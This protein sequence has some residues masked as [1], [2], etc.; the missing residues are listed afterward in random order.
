MS[1]DPKGNGTQV[2]TTR[3]RT[4]RR[5]RTRATR[6]RGSTRSWG[7]PLGVATDEAKAAA[8]ADVWKTGGS[9]LLVGTPAAPKDNQATF[10][11][12]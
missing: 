7:I 8:A 1:F 10:R 4:S 2:A 11:E 5:A 6:S 12:R 9:T 3:S